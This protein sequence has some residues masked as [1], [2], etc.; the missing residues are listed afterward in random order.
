MASTR[1]DFLAW[2]RRWCCRRWTIHRAPAEAGRR[3][4]PWE[5]LR[6]RCCVVGAGYAGL[7]G[8]L[9][10]KQGGAKV[11]LLEAQDRPGGRSWMRALPDG[12][13]VDLA[14]Q[15]VGPIQDLL[16][17]H[18]RNGRRDLPHA[19][20]RQ[21]AH[22]RSAVTMLSAFPAPTRSRRCSTHR[23]DVST[24]RSR[25]AVD[26]PGRFTPRRHDLRGLAA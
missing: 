12:G 9:R 2:R 13:W 5:T 19:R 16:C 8:A 10:P 26:S 21:I 17:A 4:V 18:P 7:A 20:V 15:W 6:R 14:G 11:V 3:S 23:G 22:A 24:H 25:S 1:R